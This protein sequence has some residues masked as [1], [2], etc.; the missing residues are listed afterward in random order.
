MKKTMEHEGD[1]DT[2]NIWRPWKNPIEPGK[3]IGKSEGV[4]EFGPSRQL[5]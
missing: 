1:S 3:E 5:E 4:K 2:N